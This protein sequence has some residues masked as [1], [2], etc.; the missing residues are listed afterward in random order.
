MT[1]C[2]P[3]GF[4]QSLHSHTVTPRASSLRVKFSG[5]VAKF[6]ALLR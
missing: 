6:S 2:S 4:L 3:F 5:S 1:L